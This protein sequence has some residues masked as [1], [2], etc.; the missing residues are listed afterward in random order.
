MHAELHNEEMK[1][2][3]MATNQ[4]KIIK[5]IL[6]IIIEAY[7]G[8]SMINVTHSSFTYQKQITFHT[9]KQKLTCFLIY[10]TTKMCGGACCVC[11]FMKLCIHVLCRIPKINSMMTFYS[12]DIL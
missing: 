5:D 9:L 11:D 10:S 7:E 12:M 6:Y 3:P 8:L 2:A 1:H 4:I